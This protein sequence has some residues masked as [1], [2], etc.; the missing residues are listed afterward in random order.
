VLSIHPSSWKGSSA[1]FRFTE[2]YEVRRLLECRNLDRLR[3]LIIVRGD[4]RETGIYALPKR[5][6]TNKDGKT[7]HYAGPLGTWTLTFFS[8]LLST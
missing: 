5:L 8:Q 7:V 1:N 4:F 6:V 2:F 3:L